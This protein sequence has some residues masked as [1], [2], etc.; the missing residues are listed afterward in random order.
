ML[1]RQLGVHG[2]LG[3][4]QRDP[5]APSPSTD[6]ETREPGRGRGVEHVVRVSMHGA[7]PSHPMQ[8]GRAEHE[9]KEAVRASGLG[10]TSVRP[11]AFTELWVHLVGDRR[12]PEEPRASSDAAN[13]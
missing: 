5:T 12:W 2:D 11:T 6:R 7:G 10:V 4:A 1:D 3:D 13:R 8:L 9:A